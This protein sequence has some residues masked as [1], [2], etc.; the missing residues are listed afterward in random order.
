MTG[1]GTLT[2][3]LLETSTWTD[4]MVGRAGIPVVQAWIVSVGGGLGSFALAHVLRVAGLPPNGLTVLGDGSDPIRTYRHLARNSQIPD[5]ERLRSDAGSTMDNLWGFPS[6]AWRE[7]ASASGLRDRLAPLWQVLT[8]PLLSDY[9]TPRAGQVYASVEREQARIGWESMLQRGVVRM[10]RRRVGGG[11]FTVLTPPDQVAGE[12]TRRVAYLSRHVH[13]AVGYPGLK[14]LPDLQAYRERHSD[15][16]RVVNAYEPHDHVYEELLRRPSTVLVRGSGIVASRI[17]QRLL[18][19]R[20][21]RGAGTTVIHLFRNYVSGPQGDSATFRRPG[22]NGVAHQGFNFPKAAWGGQLKERLERLDGPGRA[23]LIARMGGTNTPRRADWLAQLERGRNQGHYLQ[24]VGTV[25][26]VEPG[27]NQSITTVID[28]PEGH[29]HELSANVVIDATGLESDIAEN[30][31]LADLLTHG[32]AQRSAYGRFDVTPSFE[33]SGTRSEPGRL[34]ASG[35][36]TLGGFYAGVDSF[37]GLQYAALTIVDD[38][39]DVG[40]VARLT[41]GRSAAEWWRW[42]RSRPPV[43]RP[44]PAATHQAPPPAAAH[45][46]VQGGAW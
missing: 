1:D 24:R 34:Y 13:V 7:A 27:P 37:L 18:D 29:R 2:D 11:Y 40:A 20:E 21:Q 4:E 46:G 39:A 23:D 9:Y 44:I 45:P 42:V 32:G 30:R 16:S 33:L 22:H 3:E 43:A 26:R 6:Y 35:S 5:H 19:D 41:P 17:L 10:V 14:F 31:L 12:P 36:I 8:E 15:Y 25:Q 28:D 38:L